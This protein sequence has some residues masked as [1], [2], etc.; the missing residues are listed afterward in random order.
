MGFP[1]PLE[2]YLDFRGV[3]EKLAEIGFVASDGK[4]YSVTRIRGWADRGKLPFFKGPDGI[5]R[6]SEG[7][8][9]EALR[10]MQEETLRQSRRR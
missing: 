10:R 9:L 1:G 8:L 4:P 3:A 6:I 5:R 7:V 2:R